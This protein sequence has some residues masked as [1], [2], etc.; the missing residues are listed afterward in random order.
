MEDYNSSSNIIPELISKIDEK[1]SDASILAFLKLNMINQK[2]ILNDLENH[3]ISYLITLCETYNLKYEIIGFTKK[4]LIINNS[5]HKLFDNNDTFAAKKMGY[6]FL[7]KPSATK[8]Y[9]HINSTGIPDYLKK[10][11]ISNKTDIGDISKYLSDNRENSD[12]DNYGEDS[13]EEDTDDEVSNCD[14]N[15]NDTNISGQESSEDTDDDCESNENNESSSSYT[16]KKVKE[17]IIDYNNIFTKGESM[18]YIISTM[19]LICN[20]FIMNKL[21]FS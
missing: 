1:K 7:N 9:D 11:N 14:E 4:L 3:H 10:Y 17:V 15:I 8:N 13:F 6:T 2:I 18:I 19:N 21:Y 20:M 12:D 16:T 5:S